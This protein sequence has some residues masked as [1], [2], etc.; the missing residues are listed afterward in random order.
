MSTHRTTPLTRRRTL[1]DLARCDAPLSAHRAAA[2]LVPVAVELERHPR[3]PDGAPVGSEQVELAEDGSVRVHVDR[4][5][6]PVDDTAAG[7]SLGRWL[8]ELL[9]GRAPLS[10]E[11]AFEPHLRRHLPA[12]VVALMARSCSDAPG[13]WPSVA[14]WRV[15]LER[16]AGAQAAPPPPDQLRRE[17]RRRVVV[18]LALALLVVACL[19]VVLLAPAW[20]DGATQAGAPA[21]TDPMAQVLASS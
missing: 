8:F 10:G 3:A 6:G 13:Q 17:R 15:E 20:W 21:G 7:A 19:A 4:A 16:L 12:H 14:Q 11:D 1:Q 5:S 9:V 18:A 2:V